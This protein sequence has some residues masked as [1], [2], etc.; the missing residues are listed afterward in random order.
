MY[1]LRRGAAEY[2]AYPFHH[3]T[4]SGLKQAI[5]KAD[6]HI[7]LDSL[8]PS[9]TGYRLPV[10]RICNGA[11][12]KSHMAKC[13][14]VPR[15]V[16]RPVSPSQKRDMPRKLHR[17]DSTCGKVCNWCQ[18]KRKARGVYSDDSNVISEPIQAI[19]GVGGHCCAGRSKGG[20]QLIHVIA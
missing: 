4:M 7:A 17:Q 18:R 11:C 16:C 20:V 15:L 6:G 10:I 14:A 9:N 8:T 5:N 2:E 3:L 1:D 13:T 19:V 12:R